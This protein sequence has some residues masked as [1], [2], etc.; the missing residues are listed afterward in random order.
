MSSHDD[1]AGEFCC[2]GS[3]LSMKLL[4]FM[5]KAIKLSLTELVG[6]IG[7]SIQK[8][9]RAVYI[10]ALTSHPFNKRKI[11][12][13]TKREFDLANEYSYCILNMNLLSVVI[14]PL[15]KCR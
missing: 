3:I 13:K 1:T 8:K 10:P 11:F 14:I 5:S 6:P 12:N 9:P 15:E 7:R 4:G 2:A